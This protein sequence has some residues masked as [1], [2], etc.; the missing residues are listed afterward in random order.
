[1]KVN[2]IHPTA[3]VDPQAVIGNNVKI[4][5][6]SIVHSNVILG[7]NV[8]VESYCELGIETNLADGSPLIIGDNSLVRSHSIFY[9]SSVLQE[10]LVTGHRVTVREHTKA[11]KYFQIGS[12]SEIQGDCNIG[13][14][15]RF[16]SNI[17]V[18]KKTSIGNFVWLFP[19]VIL[20]NDPTPPSNDLIGCRVDDFS[21]VAAGSIILPGIILGAHSVIGANSCVTKDVPSK[22]LALGSPAKIIGPANSITLRGSEQPAYPWNEHFSRGYSSQVVKAWKL[23]NE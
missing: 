5:P 4:G 9:I 16:Q 3:I 1:M 10:G 19:Y 14:Y 22:M 15:V 17:F 6:Y 2:A 20:T 13:D 12:Q 21:V 11:G 7:D 23:S 18:G 8:Q